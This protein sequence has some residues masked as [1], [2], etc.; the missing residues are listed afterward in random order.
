MSVSHPDKMGQTQRRI[1]LT[2]S[3]GLG[4]GRDMA[5]ASGTCEEGLGQ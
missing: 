1:G 3:A 4:R 5:G 2:H